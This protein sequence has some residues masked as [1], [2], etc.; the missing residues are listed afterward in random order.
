[1]HQSPYGNSQAPDAWTVA[2]ASVETRSDFIHKTYQHLA[3]ALVAFVG[4]EALLLNLPGIDGLVRTMMGGR[5]SWL[6]VLGAFMLVSRV[7]E[8]WARSSTSQ[9]Q[10]YMGLGL[11]VLAEAIIFVPLM[12]IAIRVG[13]PAVVAKAAV[14][15]GI[16]FGGLTTMVLVSKKD[17]SFMGGILTVLGFS[18][19]GLIA[20]SLLFGFSMGSW[21]AW[22]MVAFAAGAIVYQTSN[23]VHQYQPG[24]HVAAALGLFASVAL[25]LW[26]V[27]QLFTRRN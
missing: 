7:A 21:F 2:Q 6:I 12:Y 10:Q 9:G 24:Q 8:N 14:V 4:L 16:T 1:M 13:G 5:I 15:T 3:L 11:Y 27:V 19:L 26:Y 22:A 17:F 25:L 20:A 23:V 18:A